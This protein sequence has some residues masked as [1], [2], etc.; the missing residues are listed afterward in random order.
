M[1]IL[2]LFEGEFVDEFSKSLHS[3]DILIVV[4]FKRS[5]VSLRNFFARS[6][7][8]TD[9]FFIEVI[10]AMAIARVSTEGY[11]NNGVN[12]EERNADPVRIAGHFIVLN[13]ALAGNNGV[14]EAMALLRAGIGPRSGSYRKY[15]LPARERW[16]RSGEMQEGA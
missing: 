8:L 3:E 7:E 5:G 12:C 4:F 2:E 9:V 13:Q 11:F 1:Y 6:S 15:L 10:E 16:R 14:T